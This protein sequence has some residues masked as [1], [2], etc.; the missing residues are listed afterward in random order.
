MEE[1]AKGF[2]IFVAIAMVALLLAYFMLRSTL[3]T[4]SEGKKASQ[5]PQKSIPGSLS[6]SPIAYF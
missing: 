6:S 4:K 1:F 5:S 3:R 2:F